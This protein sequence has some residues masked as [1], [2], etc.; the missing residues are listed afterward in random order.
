MRIKR[1]LAV[2][3]GASIRE[4]RAAAAAVTRTVATGND[5]PSISGTGSAE[6]ATDGRSVSGKANTAAIKDL[7]NVSVVREI[8]FR[9]NVAFV[10]F[11]IDNAP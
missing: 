3:T 7:R 9:T 11:H 2:S 10:P 4:L 1:V 8:M 5:V 6:V